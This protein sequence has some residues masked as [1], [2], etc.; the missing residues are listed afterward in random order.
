MTTII[1]EIGINHDGDFELAKE[2]IRRVA[3]VGGK[4]V[5]FQCHIPEAEMIPNKIVPEN[6][7]ESI[8]DMMHRC[9]FTEDQE[10]EL[11]EYAEGGGLRYL[12][13]PFS[14][15]A[16]DRLERL[17]VERYKIGSG[18]CNDYP[19]IEYIVKTGKPIILSTG[20]NGFAEIDKAVELIGG[21]LDCILHC[22]SEYPTPYK[23]VN[24][25]RMLDLGIRYGVPYG[26]SD[27]SEGIWTSL[28]AIALGASIVE[29]HF[30]I[31]RNLPGA[32]NPIS[33]TPEELR[34][35]IEGEYAIN[36]AK[37]KLVS[38]DQMKT[39]DFAFHSVVTTKDVKCGEK[40]MFDNIFTK[41][42]GGGI[43]ASDFH[44][45]IGAVVNHDIPKDTQLFW[46]DFLTGG[47]N[48]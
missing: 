35:L 42:P 4:F 19:L 16:V 27:H 8:W 43:P 2:M 45:C 31:D 26:I 40:L 21:Q 11:K 38:V 9:A 18:E 48:A 12:C 22:V 47:K 33:I 6:A 41:R 10:R 15:E 25:D 44:K 7:N 17:G 3:M 13:T 23:H 32:D 24:L 29:K 20:M 5:K 46:T 28:A 39:S 1:A 34:M 30:T 36:S 37:R 14:R